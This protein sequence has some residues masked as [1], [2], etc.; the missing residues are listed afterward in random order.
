MTCRIKWLPVIAV[1]S[2][3]S[4]QPATA[5]TAYGCDEL[6]E[7]VNAELMLHRTARMRLEKLD[8]ASLVADLKPEEMVVRERTYS[9]MDQALDEAS[10]WAKVYIARCK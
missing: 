6:I 7:F 1:L 4:A 2:L 5:I 8:T 10:K 9:V 3:T